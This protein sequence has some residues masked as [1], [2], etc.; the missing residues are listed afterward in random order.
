[1]DCSRRTFLTSAAAFGGGV[2]VLESASAS[3]IDGRGISNDDVF[4]GSR[5]LSNAR[6]TLQNGSP[7]SVASFRGRAL[8][9]NFWAHWC[10]NCIAEFHS[11]QIVQNATGGPAQFEV[12]LMSSPHD[13]PAD[14][15]FV[16]QNQIPFQLAFYSQ[17]GS[18]RS[19]EQT[20]KILFGNVVNEAP[21]FGLPVCYLFNRSGK[22]VLAGAGGME[23]TKPDLMPKI[24]QSLQS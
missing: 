9:I 7:A 17:D 1:M 12:V 18:A 13:W 5:A 23:W 22:V 15:A 8:L 10:R 2:S 20:A 6:F 24:I 4:A 19:A 21:K 11:M 16:S 3:A 14:Q